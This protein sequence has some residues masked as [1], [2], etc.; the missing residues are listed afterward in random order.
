MS[1]FKESLVSSWTIYVQENSNDSISDQ[2]KNT[3]KEVDVD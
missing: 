1:F 3:H 2:K